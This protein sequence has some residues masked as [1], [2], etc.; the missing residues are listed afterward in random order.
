V[1]HLY[2]D[3]YPHFIKNV[4]V[5]VDGC[6]TAPETPGLGVELRKEALDSGDAVI[7]TIAGM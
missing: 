1:Y 2:N 3:V 6:V 4:P 7:E 5:P